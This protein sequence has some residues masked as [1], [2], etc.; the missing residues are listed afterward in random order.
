MKAIRF[1]AKHDIRIEDVDPPGALADDD[2]LVRSTYCGICGTD[3]HE[4]TEGPIWTSA[5]PN[6]FSGAALPQILGHEFAGRVEAVGRGVTTLRVGDRVSIQPQVG[7]KDG[8]FGSRNLHFLSGKGATIGLSWPW[9]GM[10]EFAVVKDYTAIKLPDDVTD[11]QGALIEPAAVAVHA[12][13]RSGLQPGGSI[14]VTGA[15]PIGALTVLAARAAGAGRIL[16]SEPNANRRRRIEQLGVG[17]IV[18]DPTTESLED[19]VRQE[20]TEGIGVDA[21]VECAGNARALEA[22]IDAVRAQG[23]VVVVGLMQGKVGVSPF[24]LILKDLTIQGSL[25]Y[26]LTIW[27]RIIDMVRSGLFPIEAMIDDEIEMEDVIEKGFKPLLDPQGAMMKILIRVHGGSPAGR[28]SQVQVS[29]DSG[30]ETG[31]DA[32]LA[33]ISAAPSS[34]LQHRS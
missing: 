17:A 13:D 11:Q 31:Q 21:A 19:R 20:T 32:I 28:S 18:I 8:Y 9:G 33:E 1:H 22:C 6:S 4:F 14:L 27:P 26:P 29:Q 24:Q 10:G 12:V 16:V 23:V 15:G 30:V 5:S 3:L 25:C 2:V 34:A 7:P